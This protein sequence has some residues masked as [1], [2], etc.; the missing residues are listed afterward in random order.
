M[1]VVIIAFLIDLN[2]S[3]YSDLTQV[4]ERLKIQTET[5]KRNE[6]DLSA[7]IE[8]YKSCSK[9]FELL[10]SEKAKLEQFLN[11]EGIN[12]THYKQKCANDL[13]FCEEK[14]QDCISR[15]KKCVECE[16]EQLELT[17]HHYSLL[18]NLTVQCNIDK[19]EISSLKAKIEEKENYAVA[20]DNEFDKFWKE[21]YK[22]EDGF[23]NQLDDV[24]KK[25]AKCEQERDTNY[26]KYSECV[27]KK[28]F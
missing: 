27:N 12:F 16:K 1:L 24:N 13:H 28:W 6:K 9:E 2:Y 14:V 21:R 18:M 22:R 26:E 11:D 25:L 20:K 10:K 17:K 15:I 7:A 19:A 4:T 23:I 5:S 3:S 8:K